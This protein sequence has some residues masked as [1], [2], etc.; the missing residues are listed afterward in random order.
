MSIS[1]SNEYNMLDL[2][3]IES[4]TEPITVIKIDEAKDNKTNELQHIDIC[5]CELIHTPKILNEMKNINNI[6]ELMNN[7]YNQLYFIRFHNNESIF[8]DSINTCYVEYFQNIFKQMNKSIGVININIETPTHTILTKLQK[9]KMNQSEL[10]DYITPYIT[11]KTFTIPCNNNGVV[12]QSCTYFITELIDNIFNIEKSKKEIQLIREKFNKDFGNVLDLEL[13]MNSDMNYPYKRQKIKSNHVEITSSTLQE[14]SS[15]NK[16]TTGNTNLST[17]QLS[18]EIPSGHYTL[19]EEDSYLDNVFPSND[20]YI[21]ESTSLISNNDANL[22]KTSVLKTSN[23]NI[24]LFKYQINDNILVLYHKYL[25]KMYVIPNVSEIKSNKI[26]NDFPIYYPYYHKF[27]FQMVTHQKININILS[28]Y[29][30]EFNIIEFS[31]FIK[32]IYTNLNYS[33]KD[34]LSEMKN[35]NNLC[36]SILDIEPKVLIEYEKDYKFELP[37]NIDIETKNNQNNLN[38]EWNKMNELILSEY[39]NNEKIKICNIQISENNE[40]NKIIKIKSE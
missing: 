40:E 15:D 18:M 24:S 26:F 22:L 9:H 12:E 25:K 11:N 1:S 38:N 39:K 5:N 2:N 3:T 35:V 21:T 14:I 36:N 34:E 7:L 32:S 4:N 16:F 19:N 6:N 23:S 29:I 33:N 30:P 17:E 13:N 28:N 10:L 8:I 27:G 31:E 20:S 37:S